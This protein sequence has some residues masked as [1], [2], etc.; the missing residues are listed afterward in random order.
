MNGE[1]SL[2]KRKLDPFLVL[3]NAM[4]TPLNW[5]FLKCE[6]VRLRLLYCNANDDNKNSYDNQLLYV[7]R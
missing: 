5:N 1:M 7:R 3:V 6:S 2:N 4:M